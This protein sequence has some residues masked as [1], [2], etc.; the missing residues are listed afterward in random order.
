MT[1][2]ATGRSFDDLKAL[3]DGTLKPGSELRIRLDLINVPGIER[4]FDLA[5]AEGVFQTVLPAGLEILDV[6]GESDADGRFGLIRTRVLQDAQV[7]SLVLPVVAGVVAFV[8]AHWF[9]IVIG[10]SVLATIVVGISI[11]GTI[12][13]AAERT[14]ATVLL[15]VG[16]GLLIALLLSRRGVA[17]AT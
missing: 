8:A 10:A 6:S 4:P 1:L 14:G 3:R 9:A 11:T 7:S 17:T 5:G 16:G 12:R 15:A 13:E 2:L